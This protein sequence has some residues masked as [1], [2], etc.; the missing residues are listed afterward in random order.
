MKKIKFTYYVDKTYEGVTVLAPCGT[1]T[2][3]DARRQSKIFINDIVHEQCFY[4]TLNDLFFY[5]G[6][7]WFAF[8]PSL[9]IPNNLFPVFSLTILHML[10]ARSKGHLV[11]WNI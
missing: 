7:I 9:L 2:I 3:F 11:S 8:S 1:I 6:I 4:F 5:Y 10:R